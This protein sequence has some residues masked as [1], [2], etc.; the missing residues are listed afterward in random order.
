MQQKIC[1]VTGANS[2][3]GKAIALGLAKAGAQ[4]IMVC[5]D[6]SKGKTA[7]A[8][9]KAQSGSDQ[10]TL[11]IADLSS[12]ASIRQLAKTIHEQYSN[13]N[14]LINNAGIV[15]TKRELSVDG[16]EMTLA[17]NHLGPFLLTQLLLDL[18]KNNAP[19]RIINISSAVHKWG[20]IDFADLQFTNKKFQFIRAYAQSKLLM[21]STSF[22]LARRLAD[23]KVTINCVHP[24]AVKTN[25]GSGS[26][27]NP[28]LRLIDKFVKL[29]FTSPEAAAQVPVALALS[30]E[31]EQVNG[32][33]FVKGIAVPASVDSYDPG[34][35][36]RA[37]E[38]SDKLVGLNE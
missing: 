1:L 2:G 31:F 37:W 20:K 33:Y 26:A 22:E 28:V 25:L 4:V 9:I 12:Q 23:T 16:I 29:F 34:I 30:P 8:E 7:L 11:L 27:K 19:S 38:V 5:R 24:G 13:L 14:V 10:V 17:T 21:N 36:N 3:V 18:L 35:A 6:E 15:L 32:K